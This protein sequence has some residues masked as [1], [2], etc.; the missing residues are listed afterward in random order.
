MSAPAKPFWCVIRTG[1]TGDELIAVR[2]IQDGAK[3]AEAL[4]NALRDS[5]ETY[6]TVRAMVRWEEM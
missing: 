5:N 4:G 1:D 6:R 3:F 2:A